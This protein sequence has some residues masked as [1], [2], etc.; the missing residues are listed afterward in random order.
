MSFMYEKYANFIYIIYFLK[1]NYKNAEKRNSKYEFE[2]GILCEN[3]EH[4]MMELNNNKE[5]IN[6]FDALIDENQVLFCF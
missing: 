6:G 4:V 5:K 2:M 3:Y 1:E